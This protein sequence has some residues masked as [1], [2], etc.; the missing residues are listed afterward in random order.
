MHCI[1]QEE[2]CPNFEKCIGGTVMHQLH[3]TGQ[4]EMA[5]VDRLPEEDGM[6]YMDS[7]RNLTMRCWFKG[8]NKSEGTI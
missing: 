1:L 4:R 2:L 6:K 3:L 5:G 8:Q 7:F